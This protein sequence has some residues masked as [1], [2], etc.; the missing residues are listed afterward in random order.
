M[1]RY[2]FRL[3]DMG[4]GT[5]QAE[6]VIWHVK[7]GDFVNEDQL[8]VDVM[9][10][11]ATVE[12]P[13]PVSGRV[14]SI[15]GE[16]GDVLAVGSEILVLDTGEVDVAENEA[17]SVS[18]EVEQPAQSIRAPD[19]SGPQLSSA[20]FAAAISGEQHGSRELRSLASPSVRNRAKEA[21]VSLQ[22]I[23]GS[24]PAGRVTQSDLDAFLTSSD[25][26]K[27]GQASVRLKNEVVRHI[28]VVGLRRMISERMQDAKRRIPHF[29]YVEEVDVSDLEQMR[30]QLNSRWAGKRL[31]LT[32]I[33]FLVAAMRQAITDVPQIN[34]RFD[35][36]NGVVTQ[37]EGIHAGIATQTDQGLMVPVIR[38]VEALDLWQI[39]DQVAQLAQ[40]AREGKAP[41]DKLTGSTITITS[42]GALGGIASTPIINSPEVAIVGVNKI[43][44][45]AMVQ[46]GEI[47]IRKMINL[48]SSFDHRVIDGMIAARFVQSVRSLLEAP[49]LLLAD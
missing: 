15:V 49:A 43:V 44:E 22:A 25:G 12:I 29:S 7:K 21:G 19:G 2:A 41:K 14:L 42:L 36:T 6:L 35:D 31:K 17:N 13:S 34:A 23:K 11:K 18:A 26:Q 37:Y 32:L 30:L 28:K 27:S 9:T 45:R 38:H 40:L 39:A 46:N 48:S 20:Q 24:G 4:E 5:T 33:P 3:P 47:K 1:S 10:D 8:I 16:P